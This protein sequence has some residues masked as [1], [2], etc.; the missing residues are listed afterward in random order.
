MD[1]GIP[2]RRKNKGDKRAKA[3]YNRYKKGGALRVANR[4]ERE[5]KD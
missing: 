4:P 2:E 5:Q 3:R 1:Y